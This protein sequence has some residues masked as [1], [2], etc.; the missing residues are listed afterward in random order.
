MAECSDPS[1]ATEG[2]AVTATWRLWRRWSREPRVTL[3]GQYRTA[4]FKTWDDASPE[5]SQLLL[6]LA[7]THI[8]LEYMNILWEQKA[9]ISLLRGS[10]HV[11]SFNVK[12][13]Y[14]L[15]KDWNGWANASTIMARD[16]NVTHHLT[17]AGIT[18]TSICRALVQPC[19]L[20]LPS[21]HY[22][23]A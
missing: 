14:I 20:P 6:G 4:R 22:C 1:L 23:E 3:F 9:F 8:L 17:S 18:Q 11:Q 5:W 2:E 13:S 7:S 15:L 19:L 10:I 21:H 16:F 12:T